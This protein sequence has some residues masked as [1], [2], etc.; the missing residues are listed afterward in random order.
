MPNQLSRRNAKSPHNARVFRA[1]SAQIY[2]F[3]ST[4]THFSKKQQ[5]A[6]TNY[7]VLVY[8]AIFGLSKSF[9]NP[10]EK[11]GL[12]LLALVAWVYAVWLL[13]LIQRDLGTYHEQ[14]E[15]I[16]KHWLTEEEHKELKLTP[17]RNPALRGVAFLV[18]L[19]GVV[20]IGVGL[21][22]YSLWRA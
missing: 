8:G 13:I 18:A 16:H 12:S 15:N 10:I 11:A 9:T 14:L 7:V 19:I 6:I 2:P 20:T 21:L 22:T 3:N 17:Y 5:W 1:F 4:K